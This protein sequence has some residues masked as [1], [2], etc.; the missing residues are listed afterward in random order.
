MEAVGIYFSAGVSGSGVGDADLL[1]A[2][3][4][5]SVQIIDHFRDQLSKL[6]VRK[7]ARWINEGPGVYRQHHSPSRWLEHCLIIQATLFLKWLLSLGPLP[8]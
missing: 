1:P 2:G 8:A 3:K 4:D 7:R 6:I 5:A